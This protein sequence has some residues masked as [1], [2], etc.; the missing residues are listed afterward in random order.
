MKFEVYKDAAKEWRWRL[1]AENG[2]VLAESGEGYKNRNDCLDGIDS[3][4]G[5]KYTE[6]VILPSDSD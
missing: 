5:C 1:K 2:N 3:V 6:V 4:K